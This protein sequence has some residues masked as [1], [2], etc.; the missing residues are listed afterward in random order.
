MQVACDTATVVFNMKTHT[1][2]QVGEARK[3]LL[4]VLIIAIMSGIPSFVLAAQGTCSVT[5]QQ[6]PLGGTFTL[7]VEGLEPNAT[8]WVIL[9]QSTY[10]RGHHPSFG[11]DTDVNGSATVSRTTDA[12]P[13]DPLEVGWVHVKIYP[14]TGGNK[15]AASCSFE[16]VP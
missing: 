14:F 11:I 9:N 4:V 8:Y 13:T 12:D 16:V 10:R 1:P 3:R 5:P 6:V 7:S 15:T 2:N